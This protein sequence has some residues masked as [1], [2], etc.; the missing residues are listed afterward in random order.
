T[1][2][3]NGDAGD[4]DLL[5]LGGL[6]VTE[7][8]VV[9][10]VADS[11]GGGDGQAGDHGEH[12]GE[13]DRGD[14]RHEAGTTEFEGQQR[15]CG[16][17]RA[18]RSQDGIRSNQCGSAVTEDEG[19]QVEGTDEDDGPGDGLTCFEGGGNGVE[20]HKDVGQAGGAEHQGDGQGDEVQL[21]GQV[22][23]VLQAR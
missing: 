9:D 6:A 1:D 18:R 8:T 11:C 7:N 10:V 16:A 15:G 23:T 2:D 13:G 5:G 21:G 12:G 19:H 17:P 22:R 3:D 14:Q 4:A 20:A